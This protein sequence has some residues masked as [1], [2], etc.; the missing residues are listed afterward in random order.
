V[1]FGNF[2]QNLWRKVKISILQLPNFI[3]S[4]NYHQ[5]PKVA[6]LAKL[7]NLVT[8]LSNGKISMGQTETLFGAGS[9]SLCLLV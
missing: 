6:K 8:L 7:P 4:K 9:T 5:I 1:K 2:G 3:F